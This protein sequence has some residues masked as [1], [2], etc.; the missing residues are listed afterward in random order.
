[1][2]QLISRFSRDQTAATAIEYALIAGGFS[3]VILTAVQA[4]GGTLQTTFSNIATT[5]K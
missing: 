4:I 2:A 1:M 3:V 5:L